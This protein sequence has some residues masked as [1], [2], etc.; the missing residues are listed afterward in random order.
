M[1]ERMIRIF[2]P[3]TNIADLVHPQRW[4]APREARSL[5]RTPLS[6]VPLPYFC[7]IALSPSRSLPCRRTRS[8]I[9]CILQSKS[10]SNF[11][12]S[13]RLHVMVPLLIFD[14][15][16]VI[17]CHCGAESLLLNCVYGLQ[18]SAYYRIYARTSLACAALSIACFPY[19]CQVVNALAPLSTSFQNRQMATQKGLHLV[20]Q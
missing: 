1:V 18:I 5:H 2:S 4:E 9:E 19:V 12:R 14:F 15:A 7:I 10:Y 11:V 17:R 13:S 3:A 6:G 20:Y 16:F 8:N